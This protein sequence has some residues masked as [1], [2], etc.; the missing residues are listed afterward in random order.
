[1]ENAD[2]EKIPCQVCRKMIPKAAALH[3]EGRDYVHYFCD[4]KCLVHW[5]KEHQEELK[6]IKPGKRE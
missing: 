2:Q 3:A 4:T 6:I 1:M 5:Q